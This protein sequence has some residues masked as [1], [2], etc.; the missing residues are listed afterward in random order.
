MIEAG[1]HPAYQALFNELG[2]LGYVEGRNLIVERYSAEGRPE[3]STDLAHMVVRTQPDL[4]LTVGNLLDRSLKAATNTIPIVAS[5]A[6]PV[7]YGLVA[8]LAHPDANFTGISLDA[9]LEIWG[10]RLQILLEATPGVSRVGFL[11]SRAAWD[12]PEG[13]AIRQ[14]AQQLRTSLLGPPL[15]SPIEQSEYGRVLEAMAQQRAQGLIVGDESVNLTHRRLIVGLVKEAQ[16]PTVYWDRVYFEIG[17][18]MVYGWSVADQWRRVAGY[19]A[20]I[21]QGAKP[22]DIP[23]YLESKFQLLVNLKL[24]KSLGLTIPSSL[25]ARA[26]EVIE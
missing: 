12:G 6:D 7:A 15:Q 18:L 11:A 14:A 25:L 2:K 9:G 21:L 26:D 20:R 5:V 10:K 13:D 17:G 23:I 22:S 1:D 3:R 8:N 4:I 16:L 19:S 24:A